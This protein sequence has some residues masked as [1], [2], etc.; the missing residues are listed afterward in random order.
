MIDVGTLAIIVLTVVSSCGMGYLLGKFL[1][2]Y[3]SGRY[4]HNFF[5]G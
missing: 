2:S 4:V 3:Y 1:W 5:S